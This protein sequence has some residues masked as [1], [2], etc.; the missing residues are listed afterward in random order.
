N[1][2]IAP[3]FGALIYRRAAN[4]ELDVDIKQQYEENADQFDTHAMSII[5]RCFDNDERFAVDLLKRPAVA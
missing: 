2:S 5:D 3:L 4:L 1:S